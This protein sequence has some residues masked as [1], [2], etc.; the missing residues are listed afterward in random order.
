MHEK[1]YVSNIM[2]PIIYAP[3]L[4]SRRLQ[5]LNH[6]PGPPSPIKRLSTQPYQPRCASAALPIHI[7]N[8]G[9]SFHDRD[10]CPTQSAIQST[11]TCQLRLHLPV[12]FPSQGWYC[13]LL[14]YNRHTGLA[15]SKQ[16]P[17]HDQNAEAHQLRY[18]EWPT[19][20]KKDKDSP[21]LVSKR[22]DHI[23]V[24]SSRVTGQSTG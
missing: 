3:F 24:L 22:G 6:Y 7:L 11:Y 23:S 5:V 14:L 18:H 8:L 15:I 1:I 17:E 20:S 13:N 21:S 19:L 4:A 9:S 2:D 16:I 12:C 10:S